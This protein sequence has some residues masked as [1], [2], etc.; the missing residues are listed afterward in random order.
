MSKKMTF[1]EKMESLK[2]P[3][4][5]VNVISVNVDDGCDMAE[6]KVNRKT[7]LLGNFWDFTP[8]TH[9]TPFKFSSYEDLVEVLNKGFVSEGLLVKTVYNR[10]WSFDD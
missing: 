7:V 1:L 4:L 2:I 6:V 3:V 5:D 10:L 8:D 9:G